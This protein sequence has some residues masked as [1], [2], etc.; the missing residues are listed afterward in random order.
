MLLFSFGSTRCQSA[1]LVAFVP[2]ERW[3]RRRRI[4]TAEIRFDF[5]TMEKNCSNEWNALLIAARSVVVFLDPLI[6]FVM[7]SS[8]LPSGFLD[9]S[10]N[11][12]D[13]LLLLL[14]LTLTFFCSVGQLQVQ[15]AR[16][17]DRVEMRNLCEERN[18]IK[19]SPPTF[20][21]DRL[22]ERE[23][24][25]AHLPLPLSSL[26]TLNERRKRIDCLA[27]VSGRGE[28]EYF[29]KKHSLTIET[30]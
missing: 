7:F 21:D 9:M 3:K 26:I 18:L 20:A 23:R 29:D 1:L 6:A 27:V 17:S 22:R 30:L 25:R 4:K 24:A 8:L 12:T 5:F 11:K 16:Y 13:L 14:R 15:T 2:N 28:I 10:E 19:F